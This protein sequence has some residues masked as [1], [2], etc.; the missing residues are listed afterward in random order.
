VAIEE[1]KRRRSRSRAAGDF[2]FTQALLRC[3]QRYRPVVRLATLFLSVLSA[4][5]LVLAAELWRARCSSAHP[6]W[7]A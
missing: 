3:P 6:L 4:Q 7:Q 1:T 2:S 5:S